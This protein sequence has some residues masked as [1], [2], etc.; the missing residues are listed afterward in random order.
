MSLGYTRPYL[1]NKAKQ[2]KPTVVGEDLTVSNTVLVAQ[3][4][5]ENNIETIFDLM[6]FAFYL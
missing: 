6:E 3:V 4:V 1:K 5:I 2:N